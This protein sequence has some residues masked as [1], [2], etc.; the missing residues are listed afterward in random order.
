[1]LPFSQKCFPILP[2]FLQIVF[3]ILALTVSGSAQ[4]PQKERYHFPPQ[5]GVLTPGVQRS[6]TE[7][8][9][10]TI[11]PVEGHPDW[12]AVTPNAAWVS[13]SKVNHVVHLNA[14]TGRPDAIID[15]QKPCSGLVVA[16]ESLWIPSCGAHTLLRADAVSGKVQTTIPI[17]PADSEGGIAAGAGSI[18]LVTSKDSNLARVDTS[19]NTVV[20]NIAIPAGS[21]NPVFADGSVWIA[22]NDGNV[23]VQVDASSNKVVK[24]I[25]IGPKPRFLAVGAGSIWTLNQGDGTISRVEIKTGK[26]LATI[27]AGIPGEG[28]E[29]A[30]GSG[31]I[32]ATLFKFPI[33]RVDVATNQVVQQWIGPGGDSIR[34]AD[35]FV[36]LSNLAQGN[37][38]RFEVPKL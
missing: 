5:T 20:A 9:P 28:G 32:W 37:V 19:T 18:W 10:G 2:R 34:V 7:I 33:T 6:I 26:L 22:S 36:W 13:S 4:S 12:L 3:F 16:A 21:Y 24:T 15:V 11:F 35:G 23:L 31:A 8:H 38:W 25:P 30:F 17:G 27:N 1:M 29:I 14:I